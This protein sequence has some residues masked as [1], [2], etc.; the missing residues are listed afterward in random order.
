MPINTRFTTT[1]PQLDARQASQEMIPVRTASQEITKLDATLPDIIEAN[2]LATE[3]RTTGTSLNNLMGGIV[4]KLLSPR[5]GSDPLAN[6][7]S[8]EIRF[9]KCVKMLSS[10]L[11]D[12]I[13]A[14]TNTTKG[15]NGLSAA[16]KKAY[17]SAPGH[18]ITNIIASS[19]RD[20]I[21]EFASIFGQ[22]PRKAGPHPHPT[23]VCLMVPASRTQSL[24][25]RLHRCTTIEL[26][27]ILQVIAEMEEL[28]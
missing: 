27:Q 12:S 4:G 2:L 17:D 11:K 8:D 20:E 5:T 19:N 18:I 23:Y 26:V 28:I 22:K 7:N 6:A 14:T 3:R 21:T 25:E 10:L 13:F 9:Y 16:K 15:D 24:S 1:N